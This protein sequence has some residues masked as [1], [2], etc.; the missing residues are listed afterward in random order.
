MKILRN[1]GK[2]NSKTN[3]LGFEELVAILSPFALYGGNRK[4]KLPI[5]DD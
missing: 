3:E 5:L 4:T 1:I 2:E